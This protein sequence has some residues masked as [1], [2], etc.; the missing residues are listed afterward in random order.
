[1]GDIEIL[2]PVAPFRVV[3]RPLANRPSSLRSL[4]LGVLDNGKANAGLL[5][6]IVTGALADKVS[7][8][9]LVREHK[10]ASEGAPMEVMGRLQRC[11][12]VL[13]AIAD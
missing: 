3:N 10:G 7:D 4:R 6:D 1:M 9:Q 13:L 2:V 12:A 8:L 11:D 5:L